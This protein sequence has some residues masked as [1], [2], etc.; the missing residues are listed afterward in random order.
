MFWHSKTFYYCIWSAFCYFCMVRF[1]V[2]FL[3]LLGISV[4]HCFDKRINGLSKLFSTLDRRW[5]ARFPF[6]YDFLLL[7]FIFSFSFINHLFSVW[8][9]IC[10]LFGHFFRFLI[11][12]FTSPPYRLLRIFFHDATK[13]DCS[14]CTWAHIMAHFCVIL[15]PE[16]SFFLIFQ[17]VN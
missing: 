9:C 17:N 10:A 8:L 13:Y 16:G 2:G 4:L 11:Y 12:R 14:Y 3:Y 5:S 6:R 7:P 15:L 1:I